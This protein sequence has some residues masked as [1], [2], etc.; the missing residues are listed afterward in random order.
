MPPIA[1]DS[2]G[3]GLAYALCLKLK[4]LGE[5]QPAGIIAISPW[6]DLTL[7]GET[8]AEKAEID[9]ILTKERLEFYA[10]CYVGESYCSAELNTK[11]S[12]KLIMRL[13][14][15]LESFTKRGLKLQKR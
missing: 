6:C 4:E 5:S 12:A 7:S 10:D 14:F 1:G 2:A 8:V 15:W 11:K 3:G 13:S 9:P